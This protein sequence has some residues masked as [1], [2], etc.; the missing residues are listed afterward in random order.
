M[1]ENVLGPTDRYSAYA[2]VT[3]KAPKKPRMTETKLLKKRLISA[4]DELGGEKGLVLWA[5]TSDEN[6]RFL[7]GQIFR[8]IPVER[9]V[10][11]EAPL[12]AVQIV[13]AVPRP[14]VAGHDFTD[15]LQ[16]LGINRQK[17]LPAPIVVDTKNV[18]NPVKKMLK[19]KNERIEMNARVRVYVRKTKR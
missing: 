4:F 8:M 13:S 11:A 19:R 7:Y 17:A 9:Q 14:V 3:E 16:E 15:D 6:M 2:E 10:T 12:V 18:K 1:S 5:M